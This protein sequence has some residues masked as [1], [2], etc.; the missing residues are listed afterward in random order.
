[1][2]LGRCVRFV[3]VL[4]GLGVAACGGHTVTKQDVIARGN[5]ICAGAVRDL[6]ATPVPAAGETSLPGLATYL[7][8][9]TPILQREISNLR[10][11]PRPA[12]DRALLDRYLA[13]VT[14]SGATYRALEAA[15][16]RGDQDGVNQALAELQA[17][18][19]S[20]L[21]ARYGLNQCAGGAGTAVAR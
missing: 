17:D 3:A 11:L 8:A 1:M 13:A 15:A 9:V 5:A 18:P 2:P 4:A 12:E 10:A 21:A 14:K 7:G 19:S 16:R 20:S 6:R